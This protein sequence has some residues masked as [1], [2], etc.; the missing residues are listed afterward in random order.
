MLE[1]LNHL[2]S[3]LGDNPSLT[4]WILLLVMFVLVA[5]AAGRA[6]KM[7]LNNVD[8]LLKQGESAAQ[9]L[10]K[11]ITRLEGV[12]AAR[13]KRIEE[14]EDDQRTTI[15]F[16]TTQRREMALL[17]DQIWELQR[18]NRGLLQDHQTAL[19]QLEDERNGKAQGNR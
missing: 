9:R 13:N 4:P 15:D 18:T 10:Q 12:I 8:N 1:F 11:E 5:L 14:L 6:G 17:H 16:F 19:E 7:A 3:L 2:L